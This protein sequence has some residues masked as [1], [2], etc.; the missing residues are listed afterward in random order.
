[1]QGT[2]RVR[3]PRPTTDAADGSRAAARSTGRIRERGDIL[4]TFCL[5]LRPGRGMERDALGL[6]ADAGSVERDA[7]ASD[8]LREMSG[9]RRPG[10]TGHRR[11]T[12]A[13]REARA[14]VLAG[15]IA[16]RGGVWGGDGFGTDGGDACRKRRGRSAGVASGRR[17]VLLSLVHQTT[18]AVD[19]SRADVRATGRI[20]ELTGHPND[21]LP[22]HRL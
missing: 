15:A 17:T 9:A 5:R 16:R 20:R 7:H 2:G 10:Q 6:G 8:D 11:W 3:P 22:V 14:S 18:D 19:G 12:V 4:T 13:A 1:M 21:L